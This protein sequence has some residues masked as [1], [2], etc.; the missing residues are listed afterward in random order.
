MDVDWKPELPEP[1][2]LS[3]HSPFF[4]LSVQLLACLTLGGVG[5]LLYLALA[6]GLG[7]DTQLIEVGLSANAPAEARWQMRAFLALSHLL[8]FVAAGWVVVYLFYPPASQA[9]TYLQVRRL[10]QA[11]AVW[12][13]IGLTL[14]AAP[15]VLYL[16]QLNRALPLPD[17]LRLAEEQA[18]EMLKGLLKMDNGLELVANL[19]LIALLPAVGEEMVFRGVVQQQLL[20]LVRTPWVAILLGA[21]IFSLVHFQFEG[22][23]PR[24]LLGVILG[25][26]YWR[27]QNL[28]VPVAAHFANN[29]VQVFAQ[30]L[31]HRQLSSVNLEDDLSV[32]AYSAALSAA[33]VLALASW[34]HRQHH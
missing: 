26:L 1:P 6:A 8:T 11:R 23:F 27:F 4:V 33:A 30:Y 32:P 10:P 20:R 21:A 25:W 3:S 34:L 12:G 7:W 29:G 22:F 2:R 19:V 14:L 31:Y 9:L 13:G 24:L 17:S 28:W 18:S 15:L 16:Y 5:T